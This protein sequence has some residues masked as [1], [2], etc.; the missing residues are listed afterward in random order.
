M[1]GLSEAIGGRLIGRQ[2]H[3]SSLLATIATESSS[4]PINFGHESLGY[5]IASLDL[6]ATRACCGLAQLHDRR[7]GEARFPL[8][9]P[10]N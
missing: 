5:W 7:Y 6:D 2:A 1:T 8:W 10:P 9:L 3:G 4:A